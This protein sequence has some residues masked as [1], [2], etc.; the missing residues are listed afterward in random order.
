MIDEV[1]TRFETDIMMHGM[2]GTS[3]SRAAGFTAIMVENRKCIE[4]RRTTQCRL[5]FDTDTSVYID[6][7]DAS[8]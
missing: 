4:R 6:S 5:V 8:C 7:S 3:S 2:Q 1:S